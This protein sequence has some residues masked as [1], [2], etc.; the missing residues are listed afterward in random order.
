MDFGRSAGVIVLPFAALLATACVSQSAYY[1]QAEQLQQAQAQAAAQQSQIAKMQAENK[2]V[3]AG[4]LLFAEGGYQLG[5][6][7]EAALSQYV[8][9]LK[10]AQN[11]KIVVYGF[12][13]NRPVG[14]ALQRA[15]I[16]NNVDLSTRRAAN[17]V[18]YFR[19]QGVNPNILSAKGFGETHPVAPTIGPRA[20]PRTAASRSSWR[21]PEREVRRKLAAMLRCGPACREAHVA[22]AAR[23]WLAL[24]L[25]LPCGGC[26][27]GPDFS[28]PSVQ[29]AA[30]WLEANNPSV[31]TRTQEYRDWWTVFRDPVLNRLIEIAYNQNL[32][33]VAAGTR[34]LEAR[35][36]LGVSIGEFY[37]QL[38]QGRGAVTYNRPS[39]SDPTAIPRVAYR[40]FGAIRWG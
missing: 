36:Q 33:L 20:G 40:T 38:Q 8:P 14:P 5:P 3:V 22:P 32:T 7:G 30:K 6:N 19:S 26:L 39:H 15:G 25:M 11:T 28:R 1:E 29:L 10:S 34:V 9:Q 17:V 13:D 37:P 21:G 2:W 23:F 27:V 35:A 12:T 31:D 4:D 18:A 16:A 24:A